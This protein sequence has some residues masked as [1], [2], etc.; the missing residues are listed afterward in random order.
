MT[1]EA[2]VDHDALTRCM[3]IAQRDPD[4]AEQLQSMLRHRDWTEVAEFASHCCQ[5]RSLHLRPWQSPPSAVDED[6]PDEDDRAAQKLLRRMLAAG[7]SRYDPDPLRA[8]K[9]LRK[10]GK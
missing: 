6:D 3:E 2:Q 9:G 7:V 10:R 4:R 1:I 5:Y 8:L